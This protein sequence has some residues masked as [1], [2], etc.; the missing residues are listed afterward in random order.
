MA[1][2][3]T[4]LA[5]AIADGLGLPLFNEPALSVIQWKQDCLK[6]EHTFGCDLTFVSCSLWRAAEGDLAG[7]IQ[8]AS[9]FFGNEQAL[10]WFF[11]FSL[12]WC[13]LR[14]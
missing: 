4:R 11:G 1:E 14:S 12:C 6:R 3:F 7:F 8:H 5:M 9:P 13:S 10:G 2:A